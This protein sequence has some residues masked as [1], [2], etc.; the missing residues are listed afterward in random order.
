VLSKFFLTHSTIVLHA[1][2]NNNIIYIFILPERQH[3]VHHMQLKSKKTHIQTKILKL[4][5]EFKK[6]KK[7][8]NNNNNN[9][10]NLAL[11]IKTCDFCGQ[12]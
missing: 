11:S 10:N 8:Y 9:V 7:S 5:E 3:K 12:S 2:S 6:D 4:K 1:S